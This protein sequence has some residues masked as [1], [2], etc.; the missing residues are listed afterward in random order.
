MVEN[1]G[2]QRQGSLKSTQNAEVFRHGSF[3]YVSENQKDDCGSRKQGG[4][5]IP[6]DSLTRNHVFHHV[7][8]LANLMKW[9]LS[10]AISLNKSHLIQQSGPC[11]LTSVILCSMAA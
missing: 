5:N 10:W 2:K 7:F 9:L 6:I 4:D 3:I 1:E 11:L 8:F